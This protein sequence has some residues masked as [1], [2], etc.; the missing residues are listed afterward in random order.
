MKAMKWNIVMVFAILCLTLLTTGCDVVGIVTNLLKGALLGE[1]L[2][3]VLTQKFV[4]TPFWMW[5]GP[6]ACT[7]FL[8]LCSRNMWPW[9]FSIGLALLLMETV[10]IVWR[11]LN[12]W[13]VLLALAVLFTGGGFL[14]FVV[15]AFWKVIKPIVWV[16]GITKG[17]AAGA[18][19]LVK[20]E[21]HNDK[22]G[23]KD[24][25]GLETPELPVTAA[26]VLLFILALLG[27]AIIAAI[28][29]GGPLPQGEWTQAGWKP[30]VDIILR[31]IGMM[32]ASAGAFL[33]TARLN[34]FKAGW[35]CTHCGEWNW[36]MGAN[37]PACKHCGRHNPRVSW[38]CQNWL[39]NR[40]KECGQ[41]NPGTADH[42]GRN[43]CN[44]SRPAHAAGAPH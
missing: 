14:A 4:P 15:A 18:S 28:L 5:V 43:G 7:M 24:D 31:C 44:A 13:G 17:A 25:H 39:A 35:G 36:D 19:A 10:T 30:W 37:K 22:H 41:V 6:M 23:K 1:S 3:H 12:S 20:K 9:T 27:A 16:V 40:K 21:E 34:S 33:A 11:C 8:L 38:T 2:G 29:F 26:M 32:M 42:C